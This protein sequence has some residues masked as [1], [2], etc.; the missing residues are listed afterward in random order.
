[1]SE[2]N[3]RREDVHLNLVIDLPWC[4]TD[5]NELVLESHL[6][7]CSWWSSIH[8]NEWWIDNVVARIENPTIMFTIKQVFHRDSINVEILFWF[9]VWVDQVL[10]M[11]SFHVKSRELSIEIEKLEL[12]IVDLIWNTLCNVGFDFILLFLVLVLELAIDDIPDEISLHSFHFLASPIFNQNNF[13]CLFTSWKDYLF[14]DMIEPPPFWAIHGAFEPLN[15]DIK[16]QSWID[17][18]HKITI[19]KIEVEADIV[20]KNDLP[21]QVFT[22]IVH[23][24]LGI[25]KEI[26]KVILTLC[27]EV[28]PTKA[29]LSWHLTRVC[30]RSEPSLPNVA[31]VHPESWVLEIDEG[32]CNITI[33]VPDAHFHLVLDNIIVCWK[34]IARVGGRGGHETEGVSVEWIL[35]ISSH[36]SFTLLNWRFETLHPQELV[37]AELLD[38]LKS[39][40]VFQSSFQQVF[41]LVFELFLQ[42][43]VLFVAQIR[44]LYSLDELLLLILKQRRCLILIVRKYD[45]NHWSWRSNE[46]LWLRQVVLEVHLCL[47]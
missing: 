37:W 17:V 12:S 43:L 44:P 9:T 30:S 2:L 27:P 28:F 19:Q 4:L 38:V 10:T 36:D 29:A 34:L 6:Y 33:D 40:V 21:E 1:M 47:L 41:E 13:C 35:H 26:F 23:V 7:H 24:L 22:L 16:C 3:T 25:I 42:L 32:R 46:H 8:A 5:H 20:D 18:I 15:Y 11:H 31:L 39:S 45:W 14:N